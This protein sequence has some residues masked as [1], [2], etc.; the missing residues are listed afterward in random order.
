MRR[1]E[2]RGRLSDMWTSTL[3]LLSFSP[4]HQLYVA[5]RR[6]EVQ[7]LSGRVFHPPLAHWDFLTAYPNIVK[8]HDL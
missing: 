8:A 3:M 4:A 2:K 7:V 5:S 6:P 1:A